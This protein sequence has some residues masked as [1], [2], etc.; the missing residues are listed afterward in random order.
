MVKSVS[1]A[2]NR[3]IEAAQLRQS[4]MD[5]Q[6][7]F[8]IP[9]RIGFSKLLPSLEDIHVIDVDVAEPDGADFLASSILEDWDKRARFGE[10]RQLQ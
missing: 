2:F 3:E 8:L 10:P 9:I 1:G 7:R 6:L 4:E 5:P